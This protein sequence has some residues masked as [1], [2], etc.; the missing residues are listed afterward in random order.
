MPKSTQN[1]AGNRRRTASDRRLHVASNALTDYR[2]ATQSAI[3]AEKAQIIKNPSPFNSLSFSIPGLRPKDTALLH[4]YLHATAFSMTMNPAKL[5]DWRYRIPELA[6]VH[7]YLMHNILAFAAAHNS[8]L[9]PHSK[10]EYQRL[11]VYHQSKSA[12]LFVKEVSNVTQANAGAICSSAGFTVLTELVLPNHPCE[13]GEMGSSYDALDG[14][15]DLFDLTRKVVPLWRNYLRH[16]VDF[17]YL[18]EMIEVDRARLDVDRMREVANAIVEVEK[19][20]DNASFGSHEKQSYRH[21]IKLLAFWDSNLSSPNPRGVQRTFRVGGL[22]DDLFMRNARAREPMALL[23]VAQFCVLTYHAT[24]R[25]CLEDWAKNIFIVI[26]KTIGEREPWN[27]HV[28]RASNIMKQEPALQLP[29]WMHGNDQ[30][31][32]RKQGL[33]QSTTGDSHYTAMFPTDMT[34]I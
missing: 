34:V 29:Q 17:P 13:P 33:D 22:V 32:L 8:Y 2:S 20:L 23:I 24:I 31:V 18:Q 25:W 3:Y 11:T 4:H 16:N 28:R 30:L 7:R 6:K 19:L 14:M 26:E 12:E 9:R 27:S 5:V 1:S 21:A 10:E 15:I